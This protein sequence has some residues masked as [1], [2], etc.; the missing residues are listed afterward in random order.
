[1]LNGRRDTTPPRRDVL[2]LADRSA[3]GRGDVAAPM[4]D[5][6]V[7]IARQAI[8]LLLRLMD[9]MPPLAPIIQEFLDK[10]SR[11]GRMPRGRGR[12][13]AVSRRGVEGESIAP[14]APPAE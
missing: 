7:L 9:A 12:E 2:D 3:T 5:D 1:M 13:A 11:A 10:L 4:P 6:P 8:Q 14:P